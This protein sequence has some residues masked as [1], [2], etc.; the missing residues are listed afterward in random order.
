MKIGNLSAAKKQNLE[1]HET[2]LKAEIAEA[3]LPYEE[4]LV[5]DQFPES[6]VAKLNELRDEGYLDAEDPE[7][8]IFLEDAMD[9]ARRY[10]ENN[11]ESDEPATNDEVYYELVHYLTELARQEVTDKMG[12][13]AAGIE[14]REYMKKFNKNARNRARKNAYLG[15][16]SAGLPTLGK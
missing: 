7:D 8:I 12:A 5:S 9:V 14:H 13:V 11:K 6:V 15:P 3:I 16:T 4:Y 2:A 1:A 10:A